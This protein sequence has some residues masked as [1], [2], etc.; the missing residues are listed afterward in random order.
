MP[1]SVLSSIEM[2]IKL[3]KERD[4][5]AARCERLCAFI[6]YRKGKMPVEAHQEAC[7]L[8]DESRQAS[9][10][11]HDAELLRR[12]ADEYERAEYG[13]WGQEI[14]Q[15]FRSCAIHIEERSHD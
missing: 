11:R 4:Q 5:L 3:A 2:L 9:L 15:E 13:H 8:L 10:A 7:G 14:A 6:Q 1:A 12:L